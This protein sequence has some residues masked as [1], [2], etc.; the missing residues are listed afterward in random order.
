MVRQLEAMIWN[1]QFWNP[2]EFKLLVAGI[3]AVISQYASTPKPTRGKKN[4]LDESNTDDAVI[5]IGD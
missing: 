4:S 1:S 5:I 3:S 2:E